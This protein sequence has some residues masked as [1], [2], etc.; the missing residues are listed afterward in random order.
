VSRL[1]Q[2]V[3]AALQRFERG[4]FGLCETCHDPI[5]SERL[6]ADPMVRFCL[7]H[8]TAGEQRAL[9][10]DLE[11]ASRIQRGLLPKDDTRADGWEI[12]YH[13]RPFGAV[14]GDYCDLIPT[15]GGGAFVIVAD[16]AGKGVAAAMLMSHL[17][18]LLRTLVSLGLPLD[19][20]IERASRVFAESTPA[21]HYATL[22]CGRAEPGG[23]MEVCNA[24]HPPPLVIR[25]DGIERVESTGLPVGMFSNGRFSCVPVPLAPG[26]T[27]LLYT[28]GVIEALDRDGQEY[29]IDRLAAVAGSD[30]SKTPRQLVDACAADLAAFAGPKGVFDDV[31][32]MAVRRV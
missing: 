2:E 11:L 5:E 1:L 22:V 27:L 8:L 19:Q 9:E 3:D 10:Q 24:G 31:T 23:A 6:L 4:T 16:V 25:N 32:F 18:A 21:T 13:Y 29:G 7:D 30:R 17:S 28:D 15:G 20:M 14:S 12:V 26:D